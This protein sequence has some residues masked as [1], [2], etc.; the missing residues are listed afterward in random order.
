MSFPKSGLSNP[1]VYPTAEAAA[2]ARAKLDAGTSFEDLVAERNLTLADID[3]GDVSKADL[4][5]AGEAVF[6]LEG[7]GVVGPMQSDLGPALFRMNAVL[8]AQE[9]PF[10]EA[11]TALAS[12]MQ[13]DAARRAIADK[14]EA[15]DDL[16]A[17]GASLEDVAKEQG[18]ILATT[19]YAE[20]ADDNA[21]IA[22]YPAFRDEIGRAHV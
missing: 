6:A 17:G 14:V 3:L 8:P 4:G 9:T 19:D 15:V 2:A 10:D 5:A 21:E 20:G 11:R 16:L 12:E 7:P 22:G 1:L 18:L 13:T